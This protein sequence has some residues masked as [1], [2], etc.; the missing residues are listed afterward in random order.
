V[1]RGTEF[2]ELVGKYV[3]ADWSRD[4][5]P[6]PGESLRGGTLLGLEETAPDVWELSVLN[7][8]GIPPGETLDLYIT[9]FGEDEAGELYVVARRA[10]EADPAL[11]G[12]VVFKITPVPEPSSLALLCGVLVFGVFARKYRGL[13]IGQI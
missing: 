9:A 2:P 13:R 11:P 1:Y 3:F 7:V 5:F 10:L 6:S 4:F 12:G 8:E